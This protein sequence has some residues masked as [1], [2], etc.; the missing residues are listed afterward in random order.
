MSTTTQRRRELIVRTLIHDNEVSVGELANQLG[1]SPATVR[2][3]LQTLH[4]QGLLARTHGGAA[5]IEQQMYESFP[6][7]SSFEEQVRHEAEAK[8]RIGLAAAALVEDGDVVGL[9]PGTTTAQVARSIRQRSDITLL[10]TTVNVAMELSN[11]RDLTVFVPGG[12]LRPSWFSL[13][14]DATVRAIQDF[15]LDKVFI[16]VNGVEPRMGLSSEN[17]DEAAVNRALIVQARRRI[18]VADHTKLGVIAKA[19]FCPASEVHGLIT[20]DQAPDEA[21]APFTALGIEVIRA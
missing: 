4:Q 21:I 6:L 19:V 10:V 3:D 13:V 1:V 16:G 9:T 18:V 2:R 7:D 17:H 5:P 20:D 14:G 12:F 11:R 8:R 15:Y